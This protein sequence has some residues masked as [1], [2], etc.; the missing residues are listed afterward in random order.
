MN[1]K[2]EENKIGTKVSLIGLD[3]KKYT[4]NN[5]KYECMYAYYYFKIK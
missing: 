1:K 3:L 5:K 2:S 4:Y